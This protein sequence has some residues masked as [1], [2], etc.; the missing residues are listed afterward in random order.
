MNKVSIIRAIVKLYFVGALTISFIHIITAAQK[1]GLEGYEAW[2]TPLMIDGVALIGMI[3]RGVEFSKRTR[4]IGFWTQ[5]GAGM[6]SLIANVYA[7]DSVGGMILGVAVVGLFLFS[8]WLSDNIT[9]ADDDK[10]AERNAKARSRRAATKTPTRTR[11]PA[12]RK[13]RAV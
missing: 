12:T 1:T 9:T 6:V 8:E 10:R 11:K 4:K 13:L 3:M 7:A 2:V 5:F